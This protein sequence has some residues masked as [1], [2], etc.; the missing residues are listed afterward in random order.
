MG[1]G[2]IIPTCLFGM[3]EELATI[4]SKHALSPSRNEV[5]LHDLYLPLCN[6][7][8]TFPGSPSQL[9]EFHVSFPDHPSAIVADNVPLSHPPSGG[10]RHAL[11][12]GVGRERDWGRGGG[13][14][15]G[16]GEGYWKMCVSNATII[17]LISSNKLW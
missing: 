2:G 14:G 5:T 8:D 17:P 11:F 6:V 7:E 15:G 12:F 10:E 4:V 13:G 16:G 1:R 3:V 9:S